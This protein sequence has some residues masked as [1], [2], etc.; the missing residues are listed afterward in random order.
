MRLREILDLPQEEFDR[1]SDEE[2]ENAELDPLDV[3]MGSWVR[4]I[5]QGVKIKVYHETDVP[6]TYREYWFTTWELPRNTAEA[7][8]ITISKK[9]FQELFRA[10]MD[11][12]REYVRDILINK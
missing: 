4:N 2:L 1:L 8:E 5:T 3:M 11:E 9:E 10:S 7:R 12:V 6:S